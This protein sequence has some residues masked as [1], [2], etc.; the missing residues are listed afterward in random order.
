M[1]LNLRV[2]YPL[3][4]KSKNYSVYGKVYGLLDAS[5][6]ISITDVEINTTLDYLKV[7]EL[8]DNDE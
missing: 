7:E 2:E 5:E 4:F 3:L 8:Q 1:E 6:R